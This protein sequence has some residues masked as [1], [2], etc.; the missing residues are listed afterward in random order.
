MFVLLLLVAVAVG[1]IIG[2]MASRSTEETDAGW[3]DQLVW[4]LTHTN[5]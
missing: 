3:V 2:R 5:R 1:V 4:E